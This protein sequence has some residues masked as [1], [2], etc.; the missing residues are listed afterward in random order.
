MKQHKDSAD[1]VVRSGTV[2]NRYETT[3]NIFL[4][5]EMNV[6]LKVV[7]KSHPT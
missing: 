5:K 4:V 2:A 1:S 3:S 6:R 7:P